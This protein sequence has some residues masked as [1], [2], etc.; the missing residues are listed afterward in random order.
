MAAAAAAGRVEQGLTYLVRISST[1]PMFAQIT[2]TTTTTTI[3]LLVRSVVR[4]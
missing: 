3:T 2:S 1:K 4:D